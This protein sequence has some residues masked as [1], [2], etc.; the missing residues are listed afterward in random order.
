MV[1]M[2]QVGMLKWWYLFM[3]AKSVP[4]QGLSMP[5]LMLIDL[6]PPAWCPKSGQPVRGP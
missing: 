6:W 2:V 5:Q 4:G 3:V 1:T